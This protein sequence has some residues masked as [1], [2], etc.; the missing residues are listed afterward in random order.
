MK[1]L[2]ITPGFWLLLA[3]VWFLDPGILLPALLAAACHELGHCAT[4]RILGIPL[5]SL[6]LSALGAELAPART[7][8]YAVELPVALAGPCASLLCAALAAQWGRYLFAGLSLAL[9][10]FNLL[11]ILPLDGGRAVNSLCALLLPPP[12]DRGAAPWLGV[13]AAGLLLGA[14]IAAA[15]Q[16]NAPA[17]LPLAL[18]LCAQSVKA[19]LE[20]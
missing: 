17:L 15:V 16:L 9:G 20:R 4:L 18:W 5:R 13:A 2:H 8:P 1:A 6:R 3:A 14:A 7:L 12:L 11:P 10:V 19:L